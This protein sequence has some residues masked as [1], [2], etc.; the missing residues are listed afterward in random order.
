MKCDTILNASRWRWLLW[1]VGAMVMCALMSRSVSPLFPYDA[2]D[3][4]V[5]RMVGECWLCGALPYVDVFDNKGSY[6]YLI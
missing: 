6:L 1:F 5:Y 4:A 3:S 2:H